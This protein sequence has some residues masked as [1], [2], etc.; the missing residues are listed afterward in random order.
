MRFC[1]LICVPRSLSAERHAACTRS[2]AMSLL[3]DGQKR[4]YAPTPFDQAGGSSKQS[5]PSP[6]GGGLN[7]QQQHALE[8]ALSGVSIFLTGGAGTGKSFTL[9]RIISALKGR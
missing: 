6:G 2:V 9:R 1:P 5:K 4:P 3:A 8:L 7:Q